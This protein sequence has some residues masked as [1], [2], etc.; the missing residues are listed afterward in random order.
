MIE[1]VQTEKLSK[2]RKFAIL[3]IVILHFQL[4]L[5]IGLSTNP[6]LRV[7]TNYKIWCYFS[8]FTFT[9]YL[10]HNRRM[11]L[12]LVR[13]LPGLKF[14]ILIFFWMGISTLI[15][16][17][18]EPE[19][20]PSNAERYVWTSKIWDSGLFLNESFFEIMGIKLLYFSYCIACAVVLRSFAALEIYF[21]YMLCISMMIVFVMF[22]DVIGMRSVLPSNLG[23]IDFARV[24]DGQTH[25]YSQLSNAIVQRKTFLWFDSNN[26]ALRLMPVVLYLLYLS[27]TKSHGDRLKFAKNVALFVIVFAALIETLSRTCFVVTSLCCIIF[28]LMLRHAEMRSLFI[29][30]V[31]FVLSSILLVAYFG[32]FQPVRELFNRLYLSTGLLGVKRAEVLMGGLEYGRFN[33]VKYAFEDW[34]MRPFVGWGTTAV[35]GAA[36]GQGTANHLGWLNLAGRYGLIGLSLYLL[37][38]RKYFGELLASTRYLKKGGEKYVDLGKLVLVIVIAEL[39]TGFTRQIDII[40]NI[41]LIG[42]FCFAAQEMRDNDKKVQLCSD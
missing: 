24:T 34:L 42:G 4:L 14:I 38:L 41:A 22:S 30:A 26:I 27:I 19:G 8:F 18:F 40:N 15:A 13:N 28:I 17:V 1:K 3:T 35:L 16:Y 20:I 21:K 5:P 25:I 2:W 37:L 31:F 32:G 29:I 11:L 7:F 10:V 9:F 33:L 36:G 39:A 23:G 6:F 12:R